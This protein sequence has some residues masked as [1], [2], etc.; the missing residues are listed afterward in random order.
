MNNYYREEYY[1]WDEKTGA[2]WLSIDRPGS[3]EDKFISFED[4]RAIEAKI[5]YALENELGGVFI[6][7]LTGGY[8]QNKPVGQRNL[9][10]IY[11][12]ETVQNAHALFQN[13]N[14]TER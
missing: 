7:E 2:A 9:L 6:W 3:S 5:K 4:E 14:R 8:Q 13:L 10:L 11:L 12:K 1:N